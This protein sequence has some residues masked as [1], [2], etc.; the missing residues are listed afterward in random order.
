MGGNFDRYWLLKYLTENILT[1]GYR[2]SPYTRKCCTVLKQFDGSNFDGLARKR[3]KHQ[4][5]P[6]QNFALYSI[7]TWNSNL[8]NNYS[9]CNTSYVLPI[10]YNE[11]LVL[12]Y[13][14]AWD[15]KSVLLYHTW[16]TV[17]NC[18]SVLQSH[19]SLWFFALRPSYCFLR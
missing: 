6:F 4:N 12:T 11:L 18:S 7:Y 9:A 1:D 3:Q 8:D 10:V 16:T 15:N 5:F 2:L 17:S 13:R 19:F 14:Y